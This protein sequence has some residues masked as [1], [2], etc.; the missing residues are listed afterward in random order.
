ME[1]NEK[2][3]AEAED[4][5]RNHEVLIGEN[6]L[7]F[8]RFCHLLLL[9]AGFRSY[10]TLA[11]LSELMSITNRYLTSCLSMRSKASLIFSIGMTSTSAVMFFSP[12]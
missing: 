7:R 4:H 11:Y 10:V 8:F 2:S 6:R 5:G 3:E 12:Q 1:R 9:S